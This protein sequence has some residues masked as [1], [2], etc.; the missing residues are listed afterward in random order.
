MSVIDTVKATL[1]NK[2]VRSAQLTSI[3]VYGLLSV[4]TTVTAIVDIRTVAGGG[5][6]GINAMSQVLK[7]CE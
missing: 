3:M 4:S 7:M 1:F 2:G 6:G 5:G